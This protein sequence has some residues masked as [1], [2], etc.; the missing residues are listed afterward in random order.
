MGRG[1]SSS[2]ISLSRDRSIASSKLSFSVLGER[3]YRKSYNVV[4]RL[5]NGGEFE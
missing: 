4:E 2:S 5:G 3:L 1:S